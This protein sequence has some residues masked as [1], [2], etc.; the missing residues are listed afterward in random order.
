MTRCY[1]WT[2]RHYKKITK[3]DIQ[4]LDPTY[5]SPIQLLLPPALCSAV[6]LIFTRLTPSLSLSSAIPKD[7]LLTGTCNVSWGISN[8]GLAA[9]IGVVGAALKKVLS[10]DMLIGESVSFQMGD[11]TD[12]LGT[13]R[14]ASANHSYH[15]LRVSV[16]RQ[17]ETVSSASAGRY[18]GSCGVPHSTSTRLPRAVK[19]SNKQT[20]LEREEEREPTKHVLRYQGHALR[21]DADA[22]VP[23]Q[24]GF[25]VTP[26]PVQDARVGDVEGVLR[27]PDV[28]AVR[29]RQTYACVGRAD[30]QD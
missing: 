22:D 8:N 9:C 24:H 12:E 18:S 25:K 10:G 2:T 29:Q 16:N 7:P 1:R 17:S 11:D 26:E 5:H 4:H 27:R 15:T 28:M 23:I 30:R 14:N 19:E 13:G 20:Y 21:V 6:W 3:E